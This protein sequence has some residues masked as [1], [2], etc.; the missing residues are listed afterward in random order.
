MWCIKSE[1]KGQPHPQ[2]LSNGRGEWYVLPI[3]SGNFAPSYCV[4][5]GFMVCARSKYINYMNISAGQMGH[6]KPVSTQ[7]GHLSWQAKDVL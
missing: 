3:T 5:G 7:I 6:I 1:V 4:N 2:P